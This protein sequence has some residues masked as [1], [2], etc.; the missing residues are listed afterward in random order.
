ML[1]LSAS[2]ATIST[3]DMMTT[4]TEEKEEQPTLPLPASTF[5]PPG[6]GRDGPPLGRDTGV[7]RLRPS[8]SMVLEEAEHKNATQCLARLN[9]TCF[10]L[11]LGMLRVN[12]LGPVHN[13]TSMGEWIQ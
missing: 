8:S 5:T 4:T 7:I 1:L 11:C 2:G 3:D 9:R 6:G 10:G 13:L 12:Q